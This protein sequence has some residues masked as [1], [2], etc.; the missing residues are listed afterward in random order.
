MLGVVARHRLEKGR[1][2][3]RPYVPTYILTHTHIHTRGKGGSSVDRVRGGLF[4]EV[5]VQDGGR[6][7]HP[8]ASSR[9]R[10]VGGL[11]AGE[12]ACVCVCVYV[13]V[14]VLGGVRWGGSE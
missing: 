5:G 11:A 4:E 3:V 2:G 12:G 1:E 8:G 6:F 13:C 14:S 9:T 10:A 7:G